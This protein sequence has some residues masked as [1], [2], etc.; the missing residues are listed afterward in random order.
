[1]QNVIM[2][3]DSGKKKGPPR[4]A[5]AEIFEVVKNNCKD[6]W[7]RSD[8]MRG[9]REASD[10]PSLFWGL[11]LGEVVAEVNSDACD[12]FVTRCRTAGM[13]EHLSCVH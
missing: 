4:Y 2:F 8:L 12:G 7:Q 3:R 1:M 11:K 5:K 9:F 13:A 10:L 6:S